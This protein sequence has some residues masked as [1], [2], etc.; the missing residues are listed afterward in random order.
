MVAVATSVGIGTWSTSGLESKTK[1]RPDGSTLAS[2]TAPSPRP[3]KA[4]KGLLWD[5]DEVAS[6]LDA[7]LADNRGWIASGHSFQR[8]TTAKLRIRPATP[9]TVDRLCAPLQTRS[10]LSCRNGSLVVLNGN[11]GIWA[12]R[13]TE[14]FPSIAVTSSIMKSDTP[15]ATAIASAPAQVNLHPSCNNSRKAC[16][17]EGRILGRQRPNSPPAANMPRKPLS[18]DEVRRPPGRLVFA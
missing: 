12:P 6:I 16:S 17:P 8:T 10:E 2:N 4:P 15:S 13:D 3:T 14:Q 7:T 18:A 1:A 5:S 9:S 11:G